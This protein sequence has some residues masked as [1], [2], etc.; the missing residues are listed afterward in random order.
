LVAPLRG[1]RW[2]AD[3]GEELALLFVTDP[4]ASQPAPIDLIVQVYELTR[5]EA[6][7]A[8]SLMEGRTVAEAA[9]TLGITAQTAR[10]VLKHVLAKTGSHRQSE[11]MRLLTRGPVGLRR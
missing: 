4:E 6:R 9:S 11:L 10:T 8:A 2:G 3:R 5:S 7:L 1:R